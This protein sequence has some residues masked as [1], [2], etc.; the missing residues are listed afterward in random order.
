[1][2]RHFVT[3][4]EPRRDTM[5][6]TIPE[7][8]SSLILR[9]SS[10]FMLAS[11][12]PTSLDR[13]H[14]GA[15]IR[16]F[17][18]SWDGR[19]VALG[20][21]RQG[22]GNAGIVIV[23]AANGRVLPEGVPDL[24][25]TTSG[26]RYQ[27]SWLPDGSGFFYP[28]L[29]ALVGGDPS[30]RLARGR[31]FLHRIGTP[32]SADIPVFGF[33]VSAAVPMDKVDL[34]TRVG[35]SANSTWMFGSLFRSK[36]NGTDHYAAPLVKDNVAPAWVQISA[37]DDRI[38]S[39]SLRGDTVYAISRK[40]ADRGQLV[41]KVLGA[42]A[43]PSSAWGI[44]VPERKGVITGYVVQDDGIYFTERSA[45]AISLLRLAPGTKDAVK[46]PLPLTGSVTL[47]RGQSG[48]GATL[49]AE[50]WVSAPH[51]MV[52]SGDSARSLGVD[53]G[54][55]AAGAADLITELI[56]ARSKDGTM[57]PVSVVYGKRAL[58]NGHL[59]GSAPLLIDAYGGFGV[60]SDPGLNPLVQ[61]LVSL[62]GIYAYAHVRGGGE[63]GEAWHLAATRERKQNSIDDMIGAIEHLIAKRYTSAKRV[64]IIGTSFGAIIPGLLM[65]QRP[66]LLG[67]VLYEVG[68]P[69][70]I[71]GAQTD[72]T[73]ARNIAEIGDTDTPE[74]I[75]LLKKSSPYHQVP[76]KIALPAVIVHSAAG[77]YNFGTQMLAAKFVA[78]LQKAN[79]SATPVLWVQTPGGHQPLFGVSPQWAASALSFILWQTGASRYQPLR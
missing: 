6:T 74:G 46:V 75:R 15:R 42:G 44:V 31:Q 69:D 20:V 76:E 79:T 19:L 24:L 7:F 32:Q 66:D 64:S 48:A 56:E 60:S 21:T 40:D 73:S 62:G 3:Y 67:A 4:L 51:W 41:R 50:S 52:A 11:W 61:Y 78:R 72:P 43:S 33:D 22:D 55:S 65:T 63:L 37:V 8:S 18:P 25:T 36:L 2:L 49:S 13:L 29:S 35:T 26:T 27:V 47:A 54:Y 1:M 30:E 58:R 12:L 9:A 23:D 57:V 77:D 59:D 38:G 70:E 17:V 34:P 39:L 68:Q 10:M 53:D 28:R 45:G 16:T 71:R 5:T 14:P